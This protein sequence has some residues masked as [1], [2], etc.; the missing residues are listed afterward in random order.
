[1]FTKNNLHR[2]KKCS[3]NN[4]V[5]HIHL[6]KYEQKFQKISAHTFTTFQ[7]KKERAHEPHAHNTQDG[8]DA[9]HHRSRVRRPD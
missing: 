9:T 4:I 1:M 7:K 3:K 8:D 6:K 5:K 2:I